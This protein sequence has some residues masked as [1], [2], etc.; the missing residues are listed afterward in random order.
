MGISFCVALLGKPGKSHSLT[1]MIEDELLQFRWQV[2]ARLAEVRLCQ[3]RFL[4]KQAAYRRDGVAEC[5]FAL[6]VARSVTRRGFVTL[7]VFVVVLNADLAGAIFA[8]F[9][10]VGLRRGWFRKD[11]D[12]SCE[13]RT[14]EAAPSVGGGRDRGS[15]DREGACW[16]QPREPI[17]RRRDDSRGSRK[18]PCRRGP[19]SSR[20]SPPNRGA[21]RDLA[22][23]HHG[24]AAGR[25]AIGPAPHGWESTHA[26]RDS[27][28]VAC[29]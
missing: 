23:G 17:D 19:R 5:R 3:N 26:R 13:R 21:G 27:R 22:I 11:G 15:R 2:F 7:H 24:C 1:K 18:R 9:G 12:S 28:D 14:A 4:P 6:R 10:G 20:K 25:N 8:D 16:P 29:S